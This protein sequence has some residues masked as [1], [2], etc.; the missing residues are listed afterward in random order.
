MK[1]RKGQRLTMYGGQSVKV[2]APEDP[3][4]NKQRL[5]TNIRP[6]HWNH[7]F[8]DRFNFII[9]IISLS[10]SRSRSESHCGCFFHYHSQP[11]TR[12]SNKNNDQS[13]AA[14]K[15]PH[16]LCQ[17]D[18]ALEDLGCQASTPSSSS[19]SQRSNP[20]CGDDFR[21]TS[22][23]CNVKR[24]SRRDARTF[25]RSYTTLTQELQ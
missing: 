14:P 4:H 9:H 8:S 23:V 18:V 13:Y 17:D 2:K 20:Q 19:T 21:T 1:F 7:H 5:T 6:E 25:T 16:P 11:S 3:A 22:L 12:K 10:F 15:T 24:P